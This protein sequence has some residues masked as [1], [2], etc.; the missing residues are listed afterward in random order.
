M[1]IFFGP[2]IHDDS[3]DILSSDRN[4]M[5][6]YSERAFIYS[7]IGLTNPVSNHFVKKPRLEYQ[8]WKIKLNEA[9]G[10]IACASLL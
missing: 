5:P 9:N 1:K 8:F 3:T 2:R 7:H 10:N 6:Q 4:V